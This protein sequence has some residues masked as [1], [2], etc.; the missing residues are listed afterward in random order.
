MSP[1]AF[2]FF[3]DETHLI[4]ILRST[5]TGWEMIIHVTIMRTCSDTTFQYWG[6]NWEQIWMLMDKIDFEKF[7]VGMKCYRKGKI[8]EDTVFDFTHKALVVYKMGLN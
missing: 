5:S 1:E 7:T 8:S 2:K 4:I 3:T 6:Y